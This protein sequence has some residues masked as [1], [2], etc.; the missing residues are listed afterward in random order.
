M[1][2]DAIIE[3][4]FAIRW[5][6]PKERVIETIGVIC[7]CHRYKFRSTGAFVGV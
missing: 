2:Q 6:H 1:D 3:E 7:F 5:C 4:A